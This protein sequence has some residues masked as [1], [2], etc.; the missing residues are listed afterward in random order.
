MIAGVEMA[1]VTGCTFS[2]AY[3]TTLGAFDTSFNGG[4]V[5]G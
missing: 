1:Y 3:P 5:D 4:E 2:S